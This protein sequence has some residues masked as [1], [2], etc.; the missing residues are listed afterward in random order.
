MPDDDE[1]ADVRAWFAER[2]FE[3]TFRRTDGYEW[4]DLVRGS[5][6][7]SVLGYGRGDSKAAAAA[8]AKERYEQ[9][10]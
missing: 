5:S 3:L 9:E 6:G 4:A 2:G 8:R 7:A 10:Q 1:I